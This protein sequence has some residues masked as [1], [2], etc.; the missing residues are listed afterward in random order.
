MAQASGTSENWPERGD[1]KI[2][3]QIGR[4]R[5]LQFAVRLSQGVA[6]V[7]PPKHVGQRVA[8]MTENNAQ[9]GISIEYT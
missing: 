8:H 9:P 7:E 3:L 5:H 6:A 4:R 2:A 1:G